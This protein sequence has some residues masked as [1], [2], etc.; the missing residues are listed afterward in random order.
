M[1]KASKDFLLEL[2]ERINDAADGLKSVVGKRMFGCHAL[3]AKDAVFGLVWKEGRIGVRLPEEATFDELMSQKGSAPWK[4]GGMTMSHWVLV[5][6]P[7]HDDDRSLA[8]WVAKAHALAL[9]A[10]KATKSKRKAAPA[11]APAKGKSTVMKK[12]TRKVKAK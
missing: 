2:E 8:K 6:E 5:P 4:A 11:K 3:F 9:S 1:G 10:P 12:K 7:M